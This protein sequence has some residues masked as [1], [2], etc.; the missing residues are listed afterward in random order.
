MAAGNVGLVKSGTVAL[1]VG[2]AA[3]PWSSPTRASAFGLVAQAPELIK[4]V[5]LINI[6]AGEEVIPE[7]LQELCTPPMIAS[8]SRPA[9]FRSR[10]PS[11]AERQDTAGRLTG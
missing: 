2:M 5:N 3:T 7:L 11:G 9:S 6:L 10:P 1:E 8:A 4:H